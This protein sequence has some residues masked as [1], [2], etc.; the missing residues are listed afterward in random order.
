MT[1][2]ILKSATQLPSRTTITLRMTYY[3]NG[4]HT[5]TVNSLI[6]GDDHVQDQSTTTFTNSTPATLKFDGGDGYGSREAWSFKRVTVER[7]AS[8]VVSF[9]ITPP[10]NADPKLY[11]VY[12]G[13]ISISN[14]L[15]DHRISVP[16][17][18]VVGVWKD[19]KIWSRTSPSVIGKWLIPTV[20]NYNPSIKVN[21]VGATGIYQDLTF[22]PLA[23]N[24]ALKA[25]LGA[26]ILA[27]PAFQSRN[28][29]IEVEYAGTDQKALTQAGL[30]TSS[31]IYVYSPLYQ[32]A[33]LYGFEPLRRSTYASN[34]IFIWEGF[35][36]NAKGDFLVKLPP[37]PYRMKF[38]ALKNF[39]V[40]SN[41]NDYDVVISPVFNLVD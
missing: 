3:L 33:F 22:T 9:S 40:A 16:Y 30:K 21:N 1:L 27:I 26:Y 25:S 28:A 17:A 12:G 4:R 36:L 41:A 10:K 18:G 19:R 11:P 8:V 20:Q 23:P 37:G 39:G 35:V 13:F 6:P 29:T 15:D 32:A 14:D 5:A 34:S 38:S 31:R 7:G 2:R 24:A